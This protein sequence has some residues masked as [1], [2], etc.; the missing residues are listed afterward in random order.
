MIVWSFPFCYGRIEQF[1]FIH[2]HNLYISYPQL[3][4][5]AQVHSHSCRTIFFDELISPKNAQV[6]LTNNFMK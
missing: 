5:A 6:K 2:L 3:F 4:C 1:S